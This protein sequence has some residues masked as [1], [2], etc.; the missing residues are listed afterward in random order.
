MRLFW[1]R[2]TTCILPSALSVLSK[3]LFL[4]GGPVFRETVS[5][6]LKDVCCLSVHRR[7]D[8]TEASNQIATF[9]RTTAFFFFWFFADTLSKWLSVCPAC[10]LEFWMSS[11]VYIHY[12]NP[13][14]AF[15]WPVRVITLSH[16]PKVLTV[17]IFCSFRMPPTHQG[18]V[19]PF[20]HSA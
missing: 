1:A 18:G 11:S 14:S 19:G 8:P 7:E 16:K 5:L 13:F 4:Q 2:Q 20:S 9:R 10:N 3:N 15:F 6:Q 12:T 17:I